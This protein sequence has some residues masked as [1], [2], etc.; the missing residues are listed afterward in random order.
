MGI[1]SFFSKRFRGTARPPARGG[2]LRVRCG[3]CGEEIRARIDLAN[4]LSA[5][6]E[7]EVNGYVCRKV[8]MGEGRCFQQVEALLRFDQ[9]RRLVDH[10]VKGGDFL[11]FEV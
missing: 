10:Q 5:E 9:E 3:R 8:M 4:E 6:Y 11:G 1:S 7:G 2:W